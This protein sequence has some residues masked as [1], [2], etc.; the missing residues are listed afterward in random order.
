MMTEADRKAVAEAPP[1]MLAEWWCL[2]NRFDWP[3]EGLGEAEAV[4]EPWRPTPRRSAIM[5][6]I[7]DRIGMRECLREWNRVTEAEFALW[8]GTS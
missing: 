2:L 1:L 6:G 8:W 4:P 7:V 3:K 5:N